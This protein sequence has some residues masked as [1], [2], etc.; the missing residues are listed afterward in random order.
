MLPNKPLILT[1]ELDTASALFFNELRRKHFPPERNFLGAHLTLF[2]H[3]PPDQPIV[4]EVLESWS[5]RQI[6]FPLPIVAVAGIGNG[7]AYKIDSSLLVG[8]H[9]ALQKAFQPWL[10]RRTGRVYGRI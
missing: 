1:L 5:Q 2:H 4:I 3:L 10:T 8:E 6:A 7:V 9:K